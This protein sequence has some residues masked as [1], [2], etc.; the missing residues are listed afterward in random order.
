MKTRI[1]IRYELVD[2]FA[3]RCK[4]LGVI[5]DD[6]VNMIGSELDNI[7]YELYCWQDDEEEYEEKMNG[8]VES[9][10]QEWKQ[11]NEEY[12]DEY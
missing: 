4:E 11:I 6:Y 2:R 3:D 9:Y 1:E 5:E 8:Y 12:K 10:A 7:A